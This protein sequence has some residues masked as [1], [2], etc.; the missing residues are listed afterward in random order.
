MMPWV[1]IISFLLLNSPAW[2]EELKE[3]EHPEILCE[4][5]KFISSIPEIEASFLNHGAVE[6]VPWSGY[7]WPM[8]NMGILN[9]YNDYRFPFSLQL[10]VYADYLEKNPPAAIKLRNQGLNKLS[11]AEKYDLL[12]SPNELSLS[13]ATKNYILEKMEKDGTVPVW[14]G[15]CDGLSA[16]A[17]YFPRPAH[18]IS[19]VS[20][21]RSTQIRFYPDDIK[22]LGSYYMSLVATGQR[23]QVGMQCQARNFTVDSLRRPEEY[24]C[25]DLNPAAFHLAL[26]NRIGLYKRN[27]NLDTDL[28]YAEW[29]YPIIS[30][31]YSYY[32][33]ESKIHTP[34]FN[35]AIMAASEFKSDPYKSVR[36]KNAVKV[37]GVR[38]A[39]VRSKYTFPKSENFNSTSDDDHIETVYRYTLELDKNFNII[40]GEWEDPA[41]HPDFVWALPVKNYSPFTYVEE[42]IKGDPLWDGQQ[43]LPQAWI[44]KAT[45]N[46]ER[47][48]PLLKIIQSLFSLSE[49]KGR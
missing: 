7:Y 40:G 29:N 15:F 10:N 24:G 16:A 33:P 3:W 1:Y 32:N 23:L 22:A 43:K 37:V 25:R 27:L 5:D 9:R 13:Q 31:S 47:G 48:R 8:E 21:D 12:I 41:Q 46:A 26:V 38:M 6:R 18:P 14:Y 36:G 28:K 45:Q 4:G 17:S 42:E 39:V 35:K 34:D 44:E 30:Y 11:P 2:S 20:Y 49:K 19:V